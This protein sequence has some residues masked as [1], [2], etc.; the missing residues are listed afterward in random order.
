M[1]HLTS[2]TA[3]HPSKRFLSARRTLVLAVFASYAVWRLLV[4]NNSTLME[5][6]DS[7][8]YLEEITVFR[9][10]DFD[11]V[12]DMNA[13]ST[14]LFP[15]VGALLSIPGLGPETAARATSFLFSILLFVAVYLLGREISGW[16]PTIVGLFVLGI[17]PELIA[18]SPAI[19][20]EATYVALVYLG[21]WLYISR[22]RQ[23]RWSHAAASGLVFG[24]AFLTRMEGLIFVAILPLFHL[25]YYFW[26]GRS[27]HSFRGI[28]AWIAAFVIAFSALA[29][30]QIARVSA[31]MGTLAINGRQI[32]SQVE[33][34]PD[35]RRAVERLRGL[36][37]SPS[38]TNIFYLMEHPDEFDAPDV[39]MDVI[40]YARLVVF[41]LFEFYQ[42]KLGVLIGALVFAFFCFGLL[43]LYLNRKRI[44]A[45]FILLLLGFSLVPSLLHNVALRHVVILAPAMILV[46][47]I[48]IDW[49]S[50]QVLRSSRPSKI[51]KNVF[52][53]TCLLGVWSAWALPF[54]SA[55]NPPDRNR[56]YSRKE[57]AAPV[58][59]VQ[60]IVE[61]EGIRRP[62]V[63]SEKGYVAHYAGTAHKDTPYVDF[64][65]FIR[66]CEL[67]E[68]D[69]VYL[70]YGSMLDRGYPFLQAFQMGHLEDRFELLYRGKDAFGD[71]IEL[72][73][74]R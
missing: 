28:A 2:R 14:P 13:V 34:R 23:S 63:V 25:T 41:N 9:S 39:G 64:D 59:L 62:L 44:E 71:P 6:T 19:L 56:E 67:N 73:R 43:R 69:F 18:L 27:G 7:L 24:A 36:D 46:A 29:I 8:R 60:H 35:G 61:E 30:P 45:V 32:W 55:L 1:A 72:Y 16:R 3:D 26:Q 31:K 50:E 15:L 70:H 68:A 38:E 74:F 12:L 54:Y 17:C 48:G 21:F 4:W 65:R 33:N 52:I 22:F 57:I 47:G 42:E 11:A 58:A 40:G 49:L 51:G 5:G 53:L 66:Y 10:F 20:T 37:Y